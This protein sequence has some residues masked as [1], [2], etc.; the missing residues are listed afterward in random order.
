M[1]YTIK[2]KLQLLFKRFTYGLFKLLYG[3]IKEYEQVGSNSNS[4]IQISKI[5]TNH[6]YKIYTV[7]KARLYT[8]TI[9]DT[10][11]IKNNK[12]ISGP[13]F[14]I[15]NVKFEEINKN[16]V[17]SKGTPRLKKK[18]TGNLFALLTGGGGNYNYWH[19]MFDVLPRIKILSN[20]ININEIDNFLL[21]NLDKNFQRE[22]LDLLGI[23]K[24]KR[25][26]SIKYR[27][28][29]SE[30]II[31]TDHPYVIRN[32][33]SSEIQE[34][35]LWI[36]QWLSDSLTKNISN[37]E[38]IYYSKKIYIDRS[39]STSNQS[40]MRR[41]INENEIKLKLEE[42]GFKSVRLGKISLEKQI[43]TFRHA[44]TIVGLHGGGFSNLIF[45]RPNTKIIELKPAGAGLIYAN[46]AEK[47]K[48]NYKVISKKPEKFNQN[49]QLGFIR[50]G[51]DELT[52]EL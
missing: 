52:N 28:V 34:I 20:I 41:L 5:D 49:N 42:A 2:K 39:D 15:R 11:I 22:S 46:L 13:S 44:E 45:C 29:E 14:Q 30:K 33:A 51:I 37:S 17:F 6:S 25:I 36:I 8:D 9:H 23:P 3:E 47:C 4:E 24:K 38:N 50:V 48:L 27:H 16:I 18:I 21:P 32:K 7:F 31:T 26:S 12:I 35:P 10:A 1:I 40:L 19:W 43:Q